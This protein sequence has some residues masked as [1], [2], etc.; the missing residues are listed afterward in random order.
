MALLTPKTY[1][2]VIAL[3]CA[4]IIKVSEFKIK[5]YKINVCYSKAL[6][7]TVCVMTRSSIW[8]FFAIF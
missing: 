7:D 6:E 3:F 8:A 5:N 2:Q 4:W 1:L